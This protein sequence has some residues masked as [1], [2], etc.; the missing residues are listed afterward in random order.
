MGAFFLAVTQYGTY[1]Q[2]GTV[3]SLYRLTIVSLYKCLYIKHI[4]I[5]YNIAYEGSLYFGIPGV[6]GSC[7]RK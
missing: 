6:T 2:N 5:A 1:G 4:W 7:R 3:V